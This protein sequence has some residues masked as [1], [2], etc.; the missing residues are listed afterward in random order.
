MYFAAPR[1]RELQL[2]ADEGARHVLVAFSD[3]EF[4]GIICRAIDMGFGVLLD[5]GAYSAF[6]KGEQVR[7]E[8]YAAC[9]REYGPHVD[10]YVNLDVCTDAEATQRNQDWLEDRGFHPMPVWH[11]GEA[12][13]VLDRLLMRGYQ[14]VGLGNSI[15]SSQRPQGEFRRW[16]HQTTMEHRGIRFHGFAVGALHPQLMGL[17][18]ADSTTWLRAA[19]FGEQI[20]RRGVMKGDRYG[21]FW[22][23]QELLRH[24]IRALLWQAENMPCEDDFQLRLLS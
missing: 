20:G 21:L 11:F 1:P 22:K 7:I 2:L 6:T 5:S 18:S 3:P 4:E 14:Y 9:L 17:Y 19:K 24:N 23:R 15:L 8:D 10:A 16:V 13:E 12:Q